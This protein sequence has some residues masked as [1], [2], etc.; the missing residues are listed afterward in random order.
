MAFDTV[1]FMIENDGG[2]GISGGTGEISGVTR[3]DGVLSPCRVFLYNDTGWLLDYRRTNDVTCDFLFRFLKG[4][5]YRL[6]IED[7][8][9]YNKNPKAVYVNV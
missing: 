9:Q 8:K 4:G 5:T 2:R 6:V 7:D 1:E 3:I